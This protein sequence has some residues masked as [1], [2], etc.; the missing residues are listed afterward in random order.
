[1]RKPVDA[2]AASRDPQ[3]RDALWPVIR[4]TGGDWTT[5]SALFAETWMDRRTIR[6]YLGCL[7]AGR[8]MERRDPPG[9]APEYR[10]LRDPG[11]EAPRL[12]PDGTP[13]TQGSGTRN[14]WRT[15]RMLAE[16]SPRD[17]AAHATTDEVAVSEATAKA[18]CKALYAAGYLRVL[19]KAVP[20]KSRQAVY[21]LIR[22]T[23]P[24]APQV[25]R[26]KQV[27]DR[28]TQ[29]VFGAEDRP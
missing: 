25:Q 28:N 10:L 6:S 5:V 18:Y 23:G 19:Q 4:A 9:A 17:V 15:M 22:N 8:V 14:M 26:V 12:R 24:H 3:G 20:K 1:M 11:R 13:V 21:R 16:F 7:V 27:F 29:E 2:M